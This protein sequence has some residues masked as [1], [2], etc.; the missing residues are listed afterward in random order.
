MLIHLCLS[1][2]DAR[3]T[4][5]EGITL[6]CCPGINSVCWFWHV[7]W[8]EPYFFIFFFIPA[9]HLGACV[10]SHSYVSFT[11]RIWEC[12]LV[13]PVSPG[14]E[15]AWVAWLTFPFWF[16]VAAVFQLFYPVVPLLF[17]PLPRWVLLSSTS[18]QREQHHGDRFLCKTRQ[19]YCVYI[20]RKKRAHLMLSPGVVINTYLLH[21]CLDTSRPCPWTVKTRGRRQLWMT[22]WWP[23]PLCLGLYGYSRPS[24]ALLQGSRSVSWPSLLW[25]SWAAPS[26][27]S[28]VP[29]S[30]SSS[31][32]GADPAVV[33]CIYNQDAW[34]FM[35]V[36]AD[37]VPPR[38]LHA[39]SWELR[40][41]RRSMLTMEGAEPNSDLFLPHLDVSPCVPAGGMW[42]R[43]DSDS[44]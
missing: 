13:A 6:S 42:W 8:S 16:V 43:M 36:D 18:A 24:S 19:N 34:S 10:L 22:L 23:W 9:P 7:F 33:L 5:P 21:R 17:S 32:P 25:T 30:I 35:L 29:Q 41:S 1:A 15:T 12:V 20:E 44:K 2:T 11:S 31:P 38:R 3:V 37:I 14:Y 27:V 26:L 28:C 4:A 40:E 39:T